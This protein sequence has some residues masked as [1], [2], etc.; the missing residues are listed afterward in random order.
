[1]ETKKITITFL[2]SILCLYSLTGCGKNSTPELANERT[3]SLEG[4]SDLTISYDD[5]NIS[6]YESTNGKFIIKEYMTENKKRYH[7]DVKQQGSSIQI[8]EG[9]KPFFKKGFSRY[10]EVYLPAGY[11]ENLTVTTTDGNLDMEK[12]NLSL[13]KLRIDTTAGKI[14][15]SD[16]SASDIH[17]SSTKGGLELGTITGENIK[18]ETTRG[19]VACDRLEGCITY[20][21]TSGNL[22]V[23]SASGSGTYRADNSGR[24]SVV[25][26]KVTE[27]L[28][29]YN[30]NDSVELTLPEDLNF[31]FEAVTKNG[32][33]STNF[34]ESISI[35][36]KTAKGT[37]GKHPSVKVKAETKNGNIHV[38]Q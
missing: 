37:V 38:T 27:D 29:F 31:T 15:I 3:F 11:C 28:S 18:I 36:D 30:K 10:V 2:L 22:S 34:Q 16:A 24:L 14:K 23:K 19:E 25:Y 5:E 32:S 1:M 35:K 4:I 26:E 7:A 9:G 6:F 20:T 33:I 8:R 17:L 21:S 13:S 12:T